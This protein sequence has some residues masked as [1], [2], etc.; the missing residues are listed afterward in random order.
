MSQSPETH[1]IIENFVLSELKIG[2]SAEMSRRLQRTDIELFAAV[3]GDIN[4]AHLDESYAET[5][6]FHAVIAHGMWSG[7]LVSALLGTKLPGP[8]TIYLGQSLRFRH[9]IK[10]GD[11]VTARVE[12][13]AIDHDRGRVTLACQCVNQAAETVLSGEAEVL[14]PK[15]KIRRAASA[16]PKINIVEGDELVGQP[17]EPVP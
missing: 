8:G 10:I 6:L 9:P 15:E 13:S 7:A 17:Y 4:P 14:A 11:H 12:I 1:H 2:Q 3:S 16:L 5:T